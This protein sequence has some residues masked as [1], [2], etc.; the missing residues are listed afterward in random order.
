MAADLALELDKDGAPL[1][2]GRLG[3]PALAPQA[4]ARY[5][6]AGVHVFA[7]PDQLVEAARAC[8]AAGRMSDL[9]PV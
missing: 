9:A 6:A 7:W 4:M 1:L 2:I 5:A 8:A 3:S